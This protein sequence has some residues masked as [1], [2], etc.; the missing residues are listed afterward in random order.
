MIVQPSYAITATDIPQPSN[1]DHNYIVD[2]ADILDTNTEAEINNAIAILQEHKNKA[3]Y[4]VT[5]P[6][7]TEIQTQR[8]FKIIPATSPSRRFLESILLN[9]KIQQLKQRNGIL[10]FVSVADRS[11][12]IRSASNLKYIIRDRNIQGVIDKIIVPEFKQHKF[13]QGILKGTQALINRIDNPYYNSL[14]SSKH[15]TWESQI[16]SEC[17]ARNLPGKNGY[18]NCPTEVSYHGGSGNW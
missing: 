17:R 16:M 3:I 13:N 12:E 7:I 4:I 18:D 8:N 10:F 6:A 5:V 15:P 1:T 9:W 2:L 14:P 11:I